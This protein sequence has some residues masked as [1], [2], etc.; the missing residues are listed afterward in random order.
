MR[1]TLKRELLLLELRDWVLDRIFD[2]APD[3]VRQA[4]HSTASLASSSLIASRSVFLPE[5]LDTEVVVVEA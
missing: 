3:S 2:S 5:N 4:G 1:G